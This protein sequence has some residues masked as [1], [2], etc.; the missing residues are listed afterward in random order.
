MAEIPGT[1]PSTDVSWAE[2]GTASEPSSGKKTTGWTL[3]EA[4]PFDYF[5][6]SQR[7]Y[8]RYI[9]HLAAIAVR[10]FDSLPSAITGT[11]AGDRFYLDHAPQSWSDASQ[12]KATKHGTGFSVERLCC[13]GLRLYYVQNGELIATPCEPGALDTTWSVSLASNGITTAVNFIDTDGSIVALVAASGGT[14]TLLVVNAA[15]G[16]VIDTDGTIS[17][18]ASVKCHSNSSERRAYIEN[19]TTTVYKWDDTPAVSTFVTLSNNALG[20]AP[21]P[22]GVAIASTTTGTEAYDLSGTLLG[23]IKASTGAASAR[24]HHDGESLFLTAEKHNGYPHPTTEGPQWSSTTASADATTVDGSYLYAVSSDG[25]SL[26]F[27][28]FRKCD[29]GMAGRNTWSGT[30]GA[31]VE[32]ASD[33][34][35]LWMN[36][37]DSQNT[38]NYLTAFAIQRNPGTWLRADAPD[39]SSGTYNARPMPF[40]R[41]ALPED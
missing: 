35:Y 12:D 3:N 13:D 9:E 41:L 40:M 23:T 37:R 29:G 14:N 39:G 11:S 34:Q 26:G 2:G 30:L 4:P 5:N 10:Q 22:W 25:S 31:G 15:T 7:E 16:A 28:A 21:A 19:G 36:V 32:M 1:I 8:G 33:G 27:Y 6:W 18:P 38:T 20:L 17:N 24:M